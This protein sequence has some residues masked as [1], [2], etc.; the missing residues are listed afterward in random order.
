MA[1]PRALALLLAAA[2]LPITPALAQEA[3]AATPAP[4][5]PPPVVSTT[6]APPAAGP[7]ASSTPRIVMMPAKEV[8]QPLP[9]PDV[10]PAAQPAPRAARPAARTVRAEAAPRTIPATPV[11]APDAPVSDAVVTPVPVTPTVVEP[12]PD[13]V[14]ATP[15]EA[16]PDTAPPA[17][18]ANNDAPVWP[19]I[20]AALA[21]I[22]LIG[23]FFAR[24]RRS[25][26]EDY[27]D[28]MVSEPVHVAPVAAAPLM[29]APIVAPAPVVEEVSI[30][31]SNEA[32]VDAIMAGAAPTGD[33]PWI[34][35]GL[36][37]I[38][39]GTDAHDAIVEFELTVGN[40]GS[41][42]AEDVRISTWMFT[43]DPALS[44]NE[45]MM[46]TAPANS[47]L[48]ELTIAPG[49]GKRVDTAIALPKS[50]VH[51]VSSEGHAAFLPVVGA[52]ARYRLPDGSEGRIAASFAIGMPQGEGE[53]LAPFLMD[54][55][56]DM[57]DNVEARL[58]GDLERA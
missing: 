57:Q 50:G 41:V 11:A 7:A 38:R 4:V 29:A 26:D 5:T 21:A 39:A 32:E 36:R 47:A 18:V 23:M 48:T 14:L 55:A 19:W 1:H 8:A 28:E 24:R 40:A 13:P 12:A 10:Q 33:R 16:A 51:A 9:T 17:E 49:D 6:T 22:G 43:A 25:V 56:P 54:G 20:V 27:Y 58:Y 46:I 35:L 52:E 3:P 30:T 53:G 37:P 2:A 44:D 42:P 31:P 34:E 45:R 15:T